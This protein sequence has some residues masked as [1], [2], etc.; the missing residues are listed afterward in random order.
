MLYMHTLPHQTAQEYPGT[1]SQVSAFVCIEIQ[2][3]S[4][5]LDMYARPLDFLLRVALLSL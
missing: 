5:D 3:C 1:P 4:L 2:E